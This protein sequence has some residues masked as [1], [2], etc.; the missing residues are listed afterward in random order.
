LVAFVGGLWAGA[1]VL[2]WS[3][4][5]MTGQTSGSLE[6]LAARGGDYDIIVVGS[7][8]T[9]VNFLPAEFDAHMAE[10]GHPVTSFGLGIKGMRGAEIAYYVDRVLDLHLPNLK[11]ILADV[12][13]DQNM[14][15]DPEGGYQRR[16]I[17]WHDWPRFAM[18]VQHMFALVPDWK[19]R[20]TLLDLH[21]RHLLL[22]RLNIG[23]GL[24]AIASGVWF[25]GP[26]QIKPRGSLVTGRSVARGQRW[27]VERYLKGRT[28]HEAAR[29]Q[30]KEKR[31][32]PAN[33]PHFGFMEREIREVARRH[34]TPIAFILSPV[35]SDAR[36]ET[37]VKNDTPLEVLDFD[38]P[39]RYPELYDPG[40]R[41][42]P[43][44]L[45]YDGS[46]IFSRALADQ[47]AT[48]FFTNPA[49]LSA[50]R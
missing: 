37:K 26:A 19:Q 43:G 14:L 34:H 23:F 8:F 28:R 50:A 7:S 20:W 36:F 11:L 1:V 31:L 17:E 2:R 9:K 13:L 15:L 18:S 49:A 38:D 29:D 16:V 10:L 22:N 3:M 39:A 35:L 5:G 45:S 24:E 48:R 47:V 21:L 46:L 40:M 6:H 27:K 33:P 42:D 32:R 12:S 25:D 30:L 4:S 44:H 41:Y